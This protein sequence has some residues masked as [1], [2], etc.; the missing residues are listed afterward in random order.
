MGGQG[1]APEEMDSGL[2][3]LSV[4]NAWMKGHPLPP[5]VWS[6]HGPV[7]VLFDL[8]FLKL[9]TSPRVT[10][11]HALLSPILFTV[12]LLTIMFLWLRKQCSPDMSLFLVLT[13]A[14]GTMMWPYAYIGQETKQ[15]FFILLAGY[16]AACRWENTHLVRRLLLA[17]T[18]GLAIFVKG[19]G[20][21][22][23]PVIACMMCVQF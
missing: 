11:F 1:Y 18:C 10:R 22:L 19:T 9:G 13:A 6:R 16:L 17:I 8:P 15:S 23:W 7:P 2:R 4:A 3:M 5:M 14:F 21:T 12:E 20:S